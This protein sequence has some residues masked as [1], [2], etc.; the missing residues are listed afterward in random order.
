MTVYSKVLV[1]FRQPMIFPE[2]VSDAHW[3]EVFELKV[4]S[5]TDETFYK[6]RFS[7]SVNERRLKSQNGISENDYLAFFPKASI[8]SNKTLEID[9]NFVNKKKLSL[10]Q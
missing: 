3:D 5:N 9:F 4:M 2:N 6:G 1:H 7:D 10:D 8:I